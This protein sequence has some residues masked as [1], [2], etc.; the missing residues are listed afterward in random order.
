MYMLQRKHKRGERG[1]NYLQSELGLFLVEN[2]SFFEEVEESNQRQIYVVQAHD[3]QQG[4]PD[5]LALQFFF[6][7]DWLLY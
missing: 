3:R 5:R 4:R 2:E 7:N 6:R 1:N